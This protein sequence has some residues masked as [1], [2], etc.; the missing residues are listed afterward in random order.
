MQLFWKGGGGGG[1]ARLGSGVSRILARGV[2]KVRPDTKSG[3]KGGSPLQVRY[4]KWGPWA[5]SKYVIVN[6]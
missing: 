2:L 6:N 3:V 5:H 4:E 1:G